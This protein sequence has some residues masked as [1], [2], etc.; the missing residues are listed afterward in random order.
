[1][2][3]YRKG[4]NFERRVKADLERRGYYAVRAAGSHTK[5]DV[6]A[7]KGEIA[8]FVQCKTG[9]SIP[10][11]EWAALYRICTSPRFIPLVASSV[12]GKVT[13]HLIE[14]ERKPRRAKWVEYDPGTEQA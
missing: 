1:M 14:S 7:V 10:P 12:D 13:Y 9:G 2:D 4:A 5:I 8:L 3:R 6:F 11:A